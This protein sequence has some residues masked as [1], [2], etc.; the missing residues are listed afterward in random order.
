MTGKI[1]G[2]EYYENPV[3]TKEGK[4]RL[5]AWRN[6]I[7]R[8]NEGK[9]IAT[10]SSGED[11]TE[12]KAAEREK[13]L[14]HK[15]LLA[16]NKKM[17]QLALKDTQT[18]LYN[19]RY[20]NEF[21]ESELYRATRYAHPLSILMIDVDYFKS[22]NELYG[23][24][25]GDLVI[26]E[27]AVYLKKMV[28]RYDIV[29]RFSGA[30]FVIICPGA[31]KFKSLILAQRIFE[32]VSL[33]NFGN[34]AHIVKLKLSISIVSYPDDKVTRGS[35]LINLADKILTKVKDD[36]GNKIYSFENLVG[37]RRPVPKEAPEPV[38]VRVLKE[39][40]EKLTKK[41]KQTLIESI[42]A[43]AKTIELKDRYTGEHVESTVHY[44]TE[45]AKALHLPMDEIDNIRQAAV[46]HDLGKIGISDKIL[47][48]KTKLTK[49]EYEEIRKHPQIA[50]D[51]IRPIHFMHDIIP[52]ILY[53][54]ERWD[55]KGY[56]SGLKKEEIPVGARIIAIADVYQALT[57]N[58][59]YRPAFS[60]K[61]AIDI[62]KKGSGTQ[63][64]PMIV[65]IFLKILV[66]EKFKKEGQRHG[67]TK[68]RR[69]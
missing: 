43:F 8:N 61:N 15:E 18:G 60:Q 63:F 29:V 12:R 3:V 14:L 28:R 24:K 66:K 22:I 16:S 69:K 6:N 52:L 33:H 20:L 2:A 47:L 13:E 39:R 25:F 21:I 50:A 40:I 1:T 32:A 17:K 26:K 38:D 55:G 45:I 53:H 27:F 67:R 30:E 41:G 4:E 5:I 31:D 36:G 10:L 64:D 48:K 44:A 58:R 59:P 68:P 37:K 11:I 7:L 42:Y 35:E 56:P 65:D 57:S 46:L 23:H 62:I 51:I 19:Y 34:R 49:R 54:H 9:I